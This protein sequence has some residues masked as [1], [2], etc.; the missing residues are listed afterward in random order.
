MSRAHLVTCPRAAAHSGRVLFP[1]LL[2]HSQ[3]MCCLLD[4]TPHGTQTMNCLLAMHP[5]NHGQAMSKKIVEPNRKYVDTQKIYRSKFVAKVRPY[6]L[7]CVP[8]RGWASSPL[9]VIVALC[10]LHAQRPPRPA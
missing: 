2:S 10:L 8:A 9:C 7:L 1:C 4:A 3:A 5:H 6:L